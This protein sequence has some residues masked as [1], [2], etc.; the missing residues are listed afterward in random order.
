[1]VAKLQYIWF[2]ANGGP[3]DGP[4]DHGSTPAEDAFVRASRRVTERYSE[5]LATAGIDA[6]RSA[7]Q[8]LVGA[9]EDDASTVQVETHLHPAGNEVFRAFVPE[10]V[11]QLSAS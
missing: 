9:A 5:A 4:W 11:A 3:E 8:M 2:W 6:R 7:I 10:N 1:T